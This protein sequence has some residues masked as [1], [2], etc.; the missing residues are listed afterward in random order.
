MVL[1]GSQNRGRLK[2]A[3]NLK[4]GKLPVYTKKMKNKRGQVFLII[5]LVVIGVV[6]GLSFTYTKTRAPQEE[7]RVLDLSNEIYYEGAQVIDR[8]VY[9]NQ[10]EQI[11]SK[12]NELIGNYSQLNPDSEI[13]VIYG[14]A[15]GRT[16]RCKETGSAGVGTAG[17]VFCELQ[18]EDVRGTKGN[19][20]ITIALSEE[21]TYTFQLEGEQNFFIVLKKETTTGQEIVVT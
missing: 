4:S 10:P 6:I 5:A 17:Q 3:D 1:T 21:E 7:T 14:D 13:T 19:G 11:E 8:G 15:S 2:G 9:L 12:I 16:Y 20:E 18:I